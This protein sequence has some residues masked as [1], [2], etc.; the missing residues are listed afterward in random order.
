MSESHRTLTAL[1]L[2]DP[3]HALAE[4]AVGGRHRSCMNSGGFGD[5]AMLAEPVVSGHRPPESLLG[6]LGPRRAT[7]RTPL[8]ELEAELIQPSALVL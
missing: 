7:T 2:R 8:L 6:R 3:I 1:G 4:R 5:A